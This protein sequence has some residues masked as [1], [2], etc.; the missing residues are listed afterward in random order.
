MSLETKE[1]CDAVATG[2]RPRPLKICFLSS[3]HPPLDKRVHHKEAVALATA[4]YQVVHIAPGDGEEFVADG[5]SITTYKGDRTKLG[6][7]SRLP[8]LWRL[9]RRANADCYHCNEVDS[10]LVGVL[11]K[12]FSRKTVTFDI[13]ELHSN[14]LAER[15]FPAVLRPLVVKTTRTVLSLLTPFTDRLVLA[16]KSA[17][18]EFPRSRAKQ[19]VVENFTETKNVSQL[20]AS[21]GLSRDHSQDVT[22]VHLGAINRVRGWPQML[23]ALCKTKSSNIKLRVI[24]RFGD[25][26]QEEFL[27]CVRD[28]GLEDR[29]SFEP[30]MPYDQV[31]QE[32]GRCHIGLITFQP[33]SQNFIH[34]MPHKLFDYMLASLPTITPSCA[35]EVSD[36]VSSADCG[37]IVDSTCPDEIANA[38]DRL[39][40]DP[41]LCR[42]LGDNGRSAVFDRYNWENEAKKLV[43]MYD[44]FELARAS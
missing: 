27:R 39:A 10:W 21:C 4:G 1:Y 18:Q 31:P 14:D 34:A 19:M 5:V 17:G 35:I 16:K 30:W 6:R 24:G 15:C 44:E 11:L 13:H 22:A 32:L 25:G 33:V 29:V 8:K 41:G 38:L 12:I 7:I 36:I 42:R 26:S 28:L 3:M 43:Q 9:A 23:A 40:G 20:P 2:R 37:I